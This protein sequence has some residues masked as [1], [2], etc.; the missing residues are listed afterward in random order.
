M[1]GLIQEYLLQKKRSNLL[2]RKKHIDSTESNAYWARVS[3][4]FKKNRLA[5]WSLRILYVLLFIAIFA[6][7][8]A[9]EKPIYCKVEGE[10]FFPVVKSYGVQLGVDKWP[11]DLATADWYKLNYEAVLW[12]PIPYSAKT[13]DL[14]NNHYRSPFGPQRVES[15]KFWHWMGTDELGHDIAAGMI[16]GT[17]T[18]MLVGII[19]MSIATILGIFF[20][21]LAGFWGDDRFKVS[22]LRF[23]LNILAIPIGIFYG[24]K[25]RP[26]AW[27]EGNFGSELFKSLGIVILTFLLFNGI[28]FLF[29]RAK[30]GGKII[31]IPMDLLVMRFIEIMNSIPALLLLLS[32]VA[33]INDQS[34]IYVM[35]IIGFIRWTGIARFIRSELLRVRRL[36]YI[37]AAEALGLSKW[38]TLFR[39]AI[40]NALTP[41][42]ISISFGIAGAILLEAFF[43]FLGITNGDVTW[44]SILKTARRYPSAWWLAVLPGAAIFMTVTIFNLIGDGLSNAMNPKK[45]K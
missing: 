26:L 34:I 41:V 33:I 13:I 44:G 19:A 2:R 10:T 15:N 8:L 32:I 11:K 7:F 25:A 45:V 17:R 18:A 12:A 38:K 31:T 24:F 1:L 27:Y 43:S 20:G 28:A 5:V 14:K 39:H 30:R 35:I 37:E 42:L 23:W 29:E 3:R 16:S 36:E 22:R 6:D 9:N 21:A 40:P 4:E